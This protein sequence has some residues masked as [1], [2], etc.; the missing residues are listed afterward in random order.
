MP[1]DNMQGKVMY[2]I[3]K[4]LFTRMLR[5]DNKQHWKQALKYAAKLD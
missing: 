5:N 3:D 2:T 1:L 4:W